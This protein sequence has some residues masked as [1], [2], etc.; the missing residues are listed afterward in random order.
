MVLF[1]G[2][3]VFRVASGSPQDA[4]KEDN[5]EEQNQTN[6]IGGSGHI[7]D[8]S[9]ERVLGA[10]IR[11]PPETNTAPVARVPEP[12]APDLANRSVIFRNHG[13]IFVVSVRSVTVSRPKNA[14]S[15]DD[16][17][18]QDHVDCAGSDVHLLLPAILCATAVTPATF[19]CAKRVS[20]VTFCAGHASDHA[21]KP[22]FL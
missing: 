12:S 2:M 3:S 14:D 18:H 21:R 5:S 15:E 9:K 11:C 19:F 17:K 1:L 4:Y 6:G 8:S 7:G 20:Q 10:G 16:R 22:P 13:K